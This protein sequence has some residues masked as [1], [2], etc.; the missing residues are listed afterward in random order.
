[1]KILYLDTETTSLD[2]KTGN[3]LSVGTVDPVSWTPHNAL[4]DALMCCR[5]MRIAAQDY[6]R[7]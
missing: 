5:L 3:V 1:M 4:E 2:P 6:T 7:P